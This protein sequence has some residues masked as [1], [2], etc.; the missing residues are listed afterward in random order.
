MT[1]PVQLGRWAT[2]VLIVSSVVYAWIPAVAVVGATSAWLVARDGASRRAAI[3]VALSGG[4]VAVT[5]TW[6]TRNEQLPL[7]VGLLA[8]LTMTVVVPFELG[9]L[10][11]HRSRYREQGWQLADAL[12]ERETAVIEAARGAERNRIAGEM[13]DSLGHDLALLTMQISALQVDVEQDQE[14]PE[15]VVN[16]LSGLRAAAASAT[17]RLHDAIAF[18]VPTDDEGASAPR[19]VS[20]S[21]ESLAL[22]V[23]RARA[24][25]LDVELD[26]DQRILDV[27]PVALR[28]VCRLV[29]ESLTNAAKHASRELLS[30]RIGTDADT[31]TVTATNV[32]QPREPGTGTH[33]LGSGRGLISLRERVQL[34]GGSLS[35]DVVDAQFMM[36]AHF[37]SDPVGAAAFDQPSCGGAAQTQKQA[38]D[39]VV[40]QTRSVVIAPVIILVSASIILAFAFLVTNLASVLSRERFESIAVGQPQSVAAHALPLLQL[41]DPPQTVPEPSMDCRYYEE[42]VS[43]FERV[44]TFQVCFDDAVVT[45]KVEIAA[46]RSR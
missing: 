19:G 13:H 10:T 7:L 45:S 37:S 23:D 44:T 32:T 16:R 31:V 21:G 18:L 4:A 22:M 24:S 36:I 42:K 15:Q 6:A 40:R 33:L 35:A 17:E 29:E 11:L 43:F 5:V 12:R 38:R 39:A 30:L 34:L 3:I 8:G 25:G 9:R 1:R 14:Q 41:P 27:S 2:V 20:A 46:E 28:T 26:L